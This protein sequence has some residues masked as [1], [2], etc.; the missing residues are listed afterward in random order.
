MAFDDIPEDREEVYPCSC[1]GCEG[2]VGRIDGI[3]RC[4]TCAWAQSLRQTAVHASSAAA[5]RY[6]TLDE[7]EEAHK[8]LSRP[9]E[10]IRNDCVE[11][12]D[13]HV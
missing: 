5:S 10:M 7:F 1:E 11:E 8:N 13:E 2:I 12:C 3:W 9:T 6:P 4:N